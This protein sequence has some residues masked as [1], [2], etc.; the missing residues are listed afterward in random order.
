MPLFYR[1]IH[2]YARTL[3]GAPVLAALLLLSAC[4]DGSTNPGV[5]PGAGISIVASSTGLQVATGAP[6]V[7]AVTIIRENGYVGTVALTI[8]SVPAG[9]T[10]MFEPSVLTG[11]ATTSILT[12]TA[13]DSAV[14][15]TTAMKLRATA[16]DIDDD[17]L[18]MNVTVLKG[19]L[20]VSAG[21]S[22]V[23]VAQNGSASIPLSFVRTNGFTGAVTLIAEGLPANV[24]ATFA[25]AL[26]TSTQ[27]VS[28]LTLASLS[29]AVAGT[30]TI[31]VRAR[32]TGQT[33]KLIPVQ[34]T[35]L[36]TTT[37]TYSLSASPAA[38]S[39]VAGSASQSTITVNRNNGFAGQVAL[40]VAGFP[41]GVA[42]TITP[43]ATNPAQATLAISTTAAAVPGTYALTL[44]GTSAGQSAVSI[45]LTLKVTPVPAVTVAVSPGTLRI[46]P[47][48]FAQGAVFMTRVGGFTGDFFM[49]AEGLPTGVD[50]GFAPSPVQANTTVMT[51]RAANNAP[52]GTVTVTVKA[53]A[54]SDVGSATFVLTV[55]TAAVRN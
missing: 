42:G 34:V 13:V 2:T 37:V 20:D 54:G 48:G 18:A 8:D 50:V 45:P 3:A 30:S 12:F 51:L 35:V 40:S 27:T 21:S 6:S 4:N 55:G 23:T 44:T 41:A 39:I 26:V 33:D 10:A 24:S 5:P 7:S 29:G 19:A 1:R 47:G 53:T 16:F 46:A 14:A 49:S 28:T 32:S 52:S 25:P 31:N 9:V 36:P 22:A 43:S 17:S 11:G 15:K 38:F